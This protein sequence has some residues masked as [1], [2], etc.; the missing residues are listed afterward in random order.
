MVIASNP[1][2]FLVMYKQRLIR[3]ELIARNKNIEIHEVDENAHI[4][5]ETETSLAPKTSDN[6][7]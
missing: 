6:Y 1:I 2:K 5:I 7:L 4:E 3:K